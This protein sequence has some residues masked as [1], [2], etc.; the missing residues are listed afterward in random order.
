MALIT[1]II[2]GMP[3]I[4]YAICDLKVIFDKKEENW[5]TQKVKWELFVT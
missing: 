3:E 5:N 4:N 2:A 1:L